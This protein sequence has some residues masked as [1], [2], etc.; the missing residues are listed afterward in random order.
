MN[1]NLSL[2]RVNEMLKN[3]LTLEQYIELLQ[4]MIKE[5]KSLWI[6]KLGFIIDLKKDYTPYFR[7]F[8]KAMG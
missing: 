7:A 8:I 4:L 2:E 3:M 1:E 5:C 6:V